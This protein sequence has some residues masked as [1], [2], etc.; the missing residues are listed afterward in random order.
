MNLH[1]HHLRATSPSVAAHLAALPILFSSFSSLQY[2]HNFQ[3]P[4]KGSKMTCLL[5]HP[6]TK[7]ARWQSAPVLTCVH[8]L[9]MHIIE[10]TLAL[11][12]DRHGFS[13]LVLSVGLGKLLSPIN[14]KHPRSWCCWKLQCGTIYYI[15]RYT[16][17]PKDMLFFSFQTIHSLP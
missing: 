8:L 1:Q 6:S 3:V 5:N 12:P 7:S 4:S 16:E 15:T 13:T 11:E 9:L 2:P 14:R 17:E 10:K